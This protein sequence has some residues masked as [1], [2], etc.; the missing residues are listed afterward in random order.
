MKKAAVV[1]F[2]LLSF[3]LSAQVL[4]YSIN[5]GALPADGDSIQ[6]FI[7]Y[8]G[9]NF[10][11]VGFQVGEIVPDFTLYDT[12]DV[13]GQLSAILSDG[14]PV[15]LVSVSLTCPV[16]RHCLSNVLP[17][18]HYLYNSQINIVVIY[19]LEAHPQAPH[20]S[21]YA[22]STWVTAANYQDSILFDQPATY[23]ERKDLAVTFQN[24]SPVQV[25]MYLDGPGN[26]Y[27]QLFG[28][29]PN[30]A[31]LLAPNGMVFAKY[32]WLDYSE[33]A[34]MED[35]SLLLAS[36]GVEENSAPGNISLFPNPSADNTK[37]VVEKEKAYSFRIVDAAGRLVAAE[38]NV[39]SPV[40]D[41]EH[42]G[43]SA[44]VYSVVVE[45]ASGVTRTL[46]Y[47]RL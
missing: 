37:L 9:G 14:K 19:Q 16:S 7:S 8:T 28:P 25:S 1:F 30:N 21:P 38:S 2:S 35:I 26:E 20:I 15:L 5:N 34:A 11:Q 39:V 4:P 6:P 13:A 36:V 10:G 33:S 22:D 41:L 44:G 18:I 24:R 42:Y 23:G 17:D 32:D 47:I 46:P 29:A 45:T 40:S 27:W 31:Y 3:C 43:L 12:A